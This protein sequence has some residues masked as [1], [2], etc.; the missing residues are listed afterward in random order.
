M[1]DVERQPM[2]VLG[3]GNS[4]AN[5]STRDVFP[6]SMSHGYLLSLLWV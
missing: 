1:W 6:R 4:L 3:Q 2:R 5:P